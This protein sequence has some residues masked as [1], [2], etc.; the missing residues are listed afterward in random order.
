MKD[1]LS[2]LSMDEIKESKRMTN[3]I[4]MVISALGKQG[5]KTAE[6]HIAG[7]MWLYES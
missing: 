4:Q 7:C 5:D 1:G 2:G 3:R 6:D